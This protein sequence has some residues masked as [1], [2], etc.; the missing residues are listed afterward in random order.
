MRREAWDVQQT[1]GTVAAI[2]FKCI[3]KSNQF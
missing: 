3:F 1:I 2:E